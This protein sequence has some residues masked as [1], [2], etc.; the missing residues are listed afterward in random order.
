VGHEVSKWGRVWRVVKTAAQ[1]GML[2]GK[3]KP[4]EQAKVK[5]ILEGIDTVIEAGRAP[6]PVRKETTCI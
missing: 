6:T 5:Q 2:V 3:T 4:A 1:V